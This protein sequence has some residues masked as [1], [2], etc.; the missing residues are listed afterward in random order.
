MAEGTSAIIRP[1]AILT[2]TAAR[3]ILAFLQ[4][5]DVSQ[6]GVW[7]ASTA[8]WQRYDKP[9]NGNAGSRGTAESMGTIAV[10]Y[11]QPSKYEIT[12]YKVSI[13]AA[14]VEQGWTTDS[15]C[16]D[17]LQYAD[18]SLATCPRADLQPPPAAD[19]FHVRAKE[20]A[21]KSSIWN[22]DVGELL[23]KDVREIFG[24]K[25]DS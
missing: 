11:D 24:A 16:D 15:L 22:A 4:S 14:G 19:P 6:G 23:K 13:S 5:H 18:L 9:W 17:A 12:I 3:K 25:R 8:L 20:P 1:A 10:I 2:E 21:T 7:N